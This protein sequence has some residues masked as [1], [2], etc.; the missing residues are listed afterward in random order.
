MHRLIPSIFVLLT[1]TLFLSP[2]RGA[3]T[4]ADQNKALVRQV[5]DEVFNT[6]NVEHLDKYFTADSVDHEIMPGKEAPQ[7]CQDTIKEFL[8]VFRKAFPDLKVK[9]EDMIAEGDKV[10][11]RCTLTGTQKG[12]FMGVPATGKTFSIQIIDILRFKDGKCVEHWG[13]SDDAAMMQQLGEPAAK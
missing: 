1:L 4:T 12:E 8:S 2:A 13:M 6:G 9:V 5:Y 10:M 7:T 3:E 11:A